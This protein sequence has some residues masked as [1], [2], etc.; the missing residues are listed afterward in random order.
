MHQPRQNL[1]V[2][3]REHR[4]SAGTARDAH[5]SCRVHKAHVVGNSDQG[6]QRIQTIHDYPDIGMSEVFIE[7][8]ITESD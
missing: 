7:W 6:E 8:I 5:L 1:P 2:G 3:K 4:I